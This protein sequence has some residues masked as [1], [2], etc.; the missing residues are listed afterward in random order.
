MRESGPMALTDLRDRGL[1]VLYLREGLRRS[2]GVG[3]VMIRDDA[4]APQAYGTG[5]LV[6]PDLLLTCSHVIPDV[7]TAARG[8]V[9]FD[10]V[11]EAGDTFAKPEAFAFEPERMFVTDLTLDFTILSVA[12][13]NDVGDTLSGRLFIP[14]DPRPGKLIVGEEVNLLHHP[15][16][17][18]LQMLARGN[19]VREIS[20]DFIH[21]DADTQPGSAGA[22]VMNDQWDLV[23]LH[24]AKVTH[25]QGTLCQAIRVSSVLAHLLGVGAGDVLA[26]LLSTD[27][28][29]VEAL[30]EDG[31]P[32]TPS[33]LRSP[34]ATSDALPDT[35][36]AQ[37]PATRDTVFLCY[38]R[39]DQGEKRWKDRLDRQLG[40]IARFK[41]F[42]VWH[43][44]RIAAGVD[45]KAEIDL[46]LQRC[47][48][49]VLLIGP[50]FL[51]SD[52]IQDEELPALLSAH[53]TDGVPVFPLITDFCPY[54]R[55]P[56]GRFQSVNDPEQP[57]EA[58][59]EP[60]QNRLL[61]DVAERV[62]DAFAEGNR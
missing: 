5:F 42:S 14:V 53:K 10:Y 28:K 31:D 38:A 13:D 49:A 51:T 58:L 34:T 48:A 17:E 30:A 15:L 41:S 1:P 11:E 29:A 56:L 33:S 18:P 26:R 62:A 16:G 47:G 50:N 40:G 35:F 3:R 7:G 8:M 19:V 36:D 55:S 32:A 27:A 57:L 61:L 46:A 25:A 54:G 59:D 39:A 52:F 43:D 37:P 9:E 45:W 60:D 23:G 21:Y 12:A 22:P 2:H 6:S 44:G 24:H 20:D 4:G